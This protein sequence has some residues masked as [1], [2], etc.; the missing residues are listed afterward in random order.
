MECLTD[1]VK[2]DPEFRADFVRG[3][4]GKKIVIRLAANPHNIK[5]YYDSSFENGNLV[6]EYRRF[7]CNINNMGWDFEK[8]L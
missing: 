6:I 2:A 3:F 7:W 8:I 5:D 4:T 1:L